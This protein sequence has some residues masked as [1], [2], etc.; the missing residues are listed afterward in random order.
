MLVQLGSLELDAGGRLQLGL[1]GPRRRLDL[2]A[3][4][5][6]RI[7]PVDEIAAVGLGRLDDVVPAIEPLEYVSIDLA[8]AAL[9]IGAELGPRGA[10]YGRLGQRAVEVDGGRR[11]GIREIGPAVEAASTQEQSQDDDAVGPGR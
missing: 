8:L 3:G 4:D 11:A 9:R 6:V 1:R 7:H 5:R 2:R 10:P